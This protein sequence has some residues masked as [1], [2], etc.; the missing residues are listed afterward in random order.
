M[1][2]DCKIIPYFSPAD[3][4]QFIILDSSRKFFSIWELDAL[5]DDSIRAMRVKKYVLPD[6]SHA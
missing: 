6:M 3:N 2:S 1:T 4:T 5:E